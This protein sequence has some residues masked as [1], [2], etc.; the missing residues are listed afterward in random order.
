MRIALDAMGGDRAPEVVVLGAI[1]AAR[2][3]DGAVELLLVG[4]EVVLERELRKYP[5]APGISIV[6]ASQIIDMAD[7]SPAALLRRNSDSSIAVAMKLQKDHEVQAVISA[8]HTGAAVASSLLSLGRL[9]GVSRPAIASPM[10][11][12]RG[13]C[14]LLDAGANASCKP[15][16]LFQFA[17]MGELYASRVLGIERPKVGLLSIGEERSKGDPMTLQTHELL[18]TD[19]D[20]N[21]IGNVEGRDIPKGTADVVVCDGFVGNVILKFAESMVGFLATSIREQIMSSWSRKLGAFLLKGAVGEIRKKLDYQE[22]GGA[23]LLG[24]DGVTIIC[25]GNS[26]AKAIKNAIFVARRMIRERVNDHIKDHLQ[27]KNRASN[28]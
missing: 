9:A 16:W 27:R 25:H 24:V 22:Y 21:F 19:P 26:S 1:E 12:E 13:M 18:A 14:V 15:E 4:Q 20:I 8:G 6:P 10:P 3:L 2:E 28:G 5:P 17:V 11:T 23:P 7:K